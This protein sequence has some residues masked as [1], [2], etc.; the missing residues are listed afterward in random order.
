MTALLI[1]QL[2]S[3]SAQYFNI[4]STIKIDL[5]DNHLDNNYPVISIILRKPS[6]IGLEIALNGLIDQCPPD[7]I[8]NCTFNITNDKLFSK[9]INNKVFKNYYIIGKHN[10]NISDVKSLDSYGNELFKFNS[11][12]G[13]KLYQVKSLFI[14]DSIMRSNSNNGFL[15][16]Q[17]LVNGL[18]IDNIVF[19]SQPIPHLDNDLN[20]KLRLIG[21]NQTILLTKILKSYLH[22]HG[23]C[24][25]YD[26]NSRQPFNAISQTHCIKR[27]VRYYVKKHLKCNP[28]FTDNL[29]HELDFDTNYIENVC[30]GK[31]YLFLTNNNS[32]TI[33]MTN[34][35]VKYCPKDCVTVEYNSRVVTTDTRIGNEFWFHLSADR[36]YSKKSL[37][38]DSTQPM[39][40]YREEPVISFTDYI[41]Y[42]GGL[43]GLWFGINGKHFINKVIESRIW[44]LFQNNIY[45]LFFV[46][47]M[48]LKDIFIKLN[49]WIL[50]CIQYI[51]LLV[52]L[53]FEFCI[54]YIV[55][56]YYQIFYC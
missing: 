47:K 44:M 51:V 13:L 38:W 40:V 50:K 42:S 24:D 17:N 14:N 8:L 32:L 31:S 21:F 16:I 3:I 53:I 36:M 55:L 45:Y 49:N 25:T 33:N 43:L 54:Q 10:L 18:G 20:K 52:I 2:Y 56:I 22:K 27:C 37:V 28:F 4:T 15:E 5:R 26:G 11:L 1:R 19:D 7:T 39:F 48:F 46:I 6:K 23:K 29:L 34:K 41:S 9:Y 35:C 12:V 30:F